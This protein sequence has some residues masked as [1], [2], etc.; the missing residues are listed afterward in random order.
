MK[1]TI[2]GTKLGKSLCLLVRP[3]LNEI[4][5]I[6]QDSMFPADDSTL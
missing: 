4:F 2:R 6:N 1:R 3:F 5:R